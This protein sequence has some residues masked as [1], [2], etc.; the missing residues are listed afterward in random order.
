M[1][2]LRKEIKRM[3][4]E[5]MV[6]MVDNYV[7]NI[8]SYGDKLLYTLISEDDI[9]GDKLYLFVGFEYYNRTFEAFSYSFL[10]IDKNT[11]PKSD[12][13]TDRREVAKLLPP[14][15]KGKLLIIPIVFD[16]TRKIIAKVKPLNVIRNTTE[17]LAGNSLGRYEEITKIFTNEFGYNVIVSGKDKYG[18]HYWKLSLND[19][20]EENVMKESISNKTIKE[21]WEKRVLDFISKN[22]LS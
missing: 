12:F 4:R 6:S 22:K 5:A 13:L 15:L 9:T 1:S 21:N 11:K 14:N 16:L 18:G 8:E 17:V 10:L 19:T 3:L 2:E 7:E 20:I